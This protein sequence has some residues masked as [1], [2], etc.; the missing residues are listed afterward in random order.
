[1]E[2]IWSPW[3]FRYITT[4]GGEPGCVFCRVQE[5]QAGLAIGEQDRKNLIVFRGSLN[6]VILNLFPYTSGHLMIV[7]YVHTA[8]LEGV[9]QPTTNELMQLAKKAVAAIQTEYRPEGFN[10]GFNLGRA[11]GAGIADHLHMHIV[12][13]WTGDANFVSVIGET[14][15]LP[16]EL[17]ATYDRLKRHF[18]L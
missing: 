9:D 10:I 2:H 16:E 13:R 18:V 6:F 8:S 17:T 3:R 15:V 5:E 11:A 1:M 7:P 12:P 14:R 4:A